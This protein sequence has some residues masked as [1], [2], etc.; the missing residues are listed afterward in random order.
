MCMSVVVL[1]FFFFKQKTAYEMRI[2]DWSSDVC[3]SDLVCRS[4][5]AILRAATQKPERQ[6]ELNR[7]DDP[8]LSRV[9]LLKIQ[10]S[11]RMESPTASMCMQTK[12]HNYRGIGGDHEVDRKSVVYGKSVSGRGDIGGRRIIKKKKKRISIRIQKE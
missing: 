1:S 4:R 8:S 6:P 10:G 5:P 12:F 9:R 7:Q 11:G 3:S 2:S